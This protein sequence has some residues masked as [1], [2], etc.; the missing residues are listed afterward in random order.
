MIT[1][2][3]IEGPQHKYSDDDGR[4]WEHN[5]YFV[6]LTNEE[7]EATLETSYKLGMALTV[8]DLTAETVL[9]NLLTDATYA[10]NAETWEEFAEEFEDMDTLTYRDAQRYQRMFQDITAQSARLRRLIGEDEW[11]ATE[12]EDAEETAAR[13]TA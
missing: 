12:T 5:W 7:T 3:I 10:E 2:E 13:L 9:E 6:R 1:L 8:A 4:D 11:N